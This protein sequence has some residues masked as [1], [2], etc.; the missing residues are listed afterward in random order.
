[1]NNLVTTQP[2]SFADLELVPMQR[3][4][5]QSTPLERLL[6]AVY[7]QR[8]VVLAAI[9]TAAVV[10]ALLFMNSERSFTAAASVQFDQLTPRVLGSQDLDPQSAEKDAERFLQ[11]QLDHV[12]SRSIATSV[13]DRLNIAASPASLKAL[14][15]EAANPAQAREAAIDRLQD[16]V[17]PT[18]GL[19]T[20]VAQVSFT[21]GDPYVSARVANGFADALIAAN[22]NSKLQTSERAK[23]HLMAELA[24]AK[25]RLEGSE[26]NMLSYAR[27]A[28][29][30]TTVVPGG[31][32]KDGG[33]SLRT[34]QL[35]LLN[36]S[37]AQATA[38]RVDAQQHWAQVQGTGALALPEVQAN[39]AIQSLVAQKAQ[40]QAA[41]EE[42]RQRHTDEYPS[43][44]ET[45]AKIQELDSQ[46]GSFASNIKR[47]VQGRYVAAAQ[48]ER[49]MMQ[50][51]A[52]LR[53]AAMSERERS[54]GYNSLSR[55]VETNR[56]FYDG[57]LQR[58]KEVAAAS[59]AA[60]ANVSIIDR[61]WPPS[62][63]DSPHVGRNMAL[64]S[65]A[66]LILA[67]FVGSVRERLHKVIRSTEDL[68][69][70]FSLPA[71]GVVPRLTGGG[72]VHS[73]LQDT[74]SAQAEAYHSIA[75][76]LAEQASGVLPKTLLITS[77]TAAEGKSTSALGIARSLS[78]MGK[79]VLLIDADL[80]RPSSSNLLE[81]TDGPG[82]AEVL[83]GTASP[84][85]AIERS[86]EGFNVIRAGSSSSSPVSLLAADHLKAV[87]DRLSEDHDTII[88][89]G[90]PVMGLA[91]AVLLAR[92]V[93][94]VLVVVEAN[95][96]HTSELDLAVSRLPGSNV[97]GGVITK[98]DPKTA[99][100]RYGG[101]DYYKYS[102][103]GN[104]G[105]GHGVSGGA[106]LPAPA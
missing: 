34:Q 56:A 94:A 43:V 37:L 57:L 11:T 102:D 24:K 66:G 33:G 81:E 103:G 99:G 32:N 80:R 68:E 1:M 93:E 45:A 47:S 77:S 61:A 88:I 19:N 67:L 7:R 48:Q 90:P 79:R 78:A 65:L 106:S 55:E 83:A 28:D 86:S 100:V 69:Q 71:L 14:G 74:R 104:R 18:L 36:D 41:L 54:V 58:Y 62:A 44:R 31:D 6:T 5:S 4:V 98:F 64:A 29:L 70:G 53:G 76:A 63:A 42:D 91:D 51:V 85:L 92:S 20:R 82:L 27:S 9:I 13:A 49:Q 22:M 25:Q 84:D 10:A 46:I 75:V 52:G 50:T 97:I 23:A 72:D 38:R 30:T 101:Y 105:R 3:Q 89:D 73:A 95:R 12:G 87:L 16:G 60:A 26:R 96:T 2:R 15:V 21:S 59:G 35:G 17:G 8:W 39:Q 40:L